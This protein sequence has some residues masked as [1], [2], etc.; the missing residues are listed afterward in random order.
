MLFVGSPGV[1]KTLAA[2]WL[3]QRLNRPLL[4][5]DLSAVMSS[6]LGRTGGNIRAVLDHARSFPSVL[7]LDEFD[8]I[9][10]RRDDA[11]E[12]GELKRL[13]TVLLQSIDDWPAHS[14]L[15]AATNHPELL[16]PAVWRRFERVVE[17]P[18]PSD[19]DIRRTVATIL[20]TTKDGLDPG[21]LAAVL[22][23]KSFAEITRLITAARREAILTGISA[24]AAL[25]GSL[26]DEIRGGAKTAQLRLAAELAR[27]NRSQREISEITGLSRDTLRKHSH[28]DDANATPK[29]GRSR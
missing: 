26:H 18:L 2:R 9:A 22:S 14:L 16:D 15:L 19:D 10:K 23:G 6:F 5:L 27:R 4:V 28:A 1:G 20:P 29:K 7:L 11:S 13:V 25:L 17:F 3:A 24:D 8:S 21:V 12:I